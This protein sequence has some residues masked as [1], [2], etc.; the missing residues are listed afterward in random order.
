[1]SLAEQTAM[2]FTPA[3]FDASSAAWHANKIRRGPAYVYRC[4]AVTAA[5]SPCKNP[6]TATAADPIATKHLC[7]THKRSHKSE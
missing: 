6:A 3:F 4:E 2:E 1:M 5:G 7:K